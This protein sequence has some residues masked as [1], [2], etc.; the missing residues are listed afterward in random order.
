MTDNLWQR[1]R[2]CVQS[3]PLDCDRLFNGRKLPDDEIRRLGWARTGGQHQVLANV[4]QVPAAHREVVGQPSHLP[5]LRVDHHQLHVAAPQR[6]QNQP[7]AVLRPTGLV[8][9]I[10]V[11]SWK[12]VCACRTTDGV[13]DRYDPL[14]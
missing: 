4:Q 10:G 6:A 1:F 9:M 2:L 12:V 8:E 11:Y 5:G 7:L 14:R 13:Y 3:K